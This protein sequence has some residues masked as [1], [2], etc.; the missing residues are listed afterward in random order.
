[1]KVVTSFKSALA[2][3]VLGVSMVSASANAVVFV[4]DSFADGDRAR[5]GAL[6]ANWWSS[7]QTDGGNVQDG[8]LG[9]L[10]LVS[11]PSDSSGLH[12][13]FAPQNLDVGDSIT[14]TYSFTTPNTVG[15]SR[16]S[17]F[18]IALMDLDDPL[19]AGDQFSSTEEA[20]PLY[21]GQAGYFTSFDIN[22]GARSDIDFRKH[23][24]TATTGTFLRSASE[25]DRISSSPN[26]GY[27]ITGNTDYVGVFSITRTGADSLDLFSSLSLASGALLDSHTAS[28]TSDI[29]NNFGVLGFWAVN[30]AFGSSSNAGDADNG[31]TLTNVTIASTAFTFENTPIATPVPAAAWLFGSALIGL[32]I[33]RRK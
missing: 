21:V 28:D 14:V 13:T 31:L 24:V 26:A 22:S 30:D 5:T 19:L 27:E 33:L 15:T 17:G 25:W 3:I 12:A 11:G 18:R 8:T 4:N 10:T 16:A 2:P 32:S 6:D 20:N 7:S 29:A 1:M 9:Q 23:D